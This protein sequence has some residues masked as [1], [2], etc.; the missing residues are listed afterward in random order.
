[1]YEFSNEI[2]KD[3]YRAFGENE[4]DDMWHRLARGAA[5]VEHPEKRQ[6]IEDDFYSILKDFK[7]VPGGRIMA[8][9]GIEGREA[10][11]LYNCF[12]HVPGDLGLKDPDSITGI[13]T[14]LT[15]QAQTLKS[16][17]GK[18]AL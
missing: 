13:Y 18:I 15:A 3:N 4:V 17:G 5:A 14:L 7:F 8:N 12:V 16:E 10:T 11:T 2:W 9:L 6:Q 1:M